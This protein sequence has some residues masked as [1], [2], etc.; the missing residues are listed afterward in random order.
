MLR[1]ELFKQGCDFRWRFRRGRRT[2][3]F[4]TPR[5]NKRSMR[6]S[7][8]ALLK[9]IQADDFMVY[10]LTNETPT[11]KPQPKKNG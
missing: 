7:L 10:D 9:D 5:M 8:V 2:L 6:L 3:A 4:S 11:K 1:L